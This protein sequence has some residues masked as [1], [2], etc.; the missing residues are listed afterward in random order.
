MTTLRSIIL[1]DDYLTSNIT[2]QDP[3]PF[4]L[5]TPSWGDEYDARIEQIKSAVSKQIFS[6]DHA[7]TGKEVANLINDYHNLVTSLISNKQ[8][9]LDTETYEMQHYAQMSYRDLLDRC[10]PND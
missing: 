6:S 5:D 4:G 9:W 1:N 7:F 2:R 3:N 10:C 8:T